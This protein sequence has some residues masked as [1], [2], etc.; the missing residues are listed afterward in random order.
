MGHTP[1]GYRIEMG[2]AVI[3]EEDAVKIRRLYDNYLSGMSLTDAA[4]QAGINTYHG[5]VKRIMC[6]R[7]Y[8][9]DEYYPA[10]I[11]SD[12]FNQAQTELKRRAVK[13]GRVN[14][15]VPKKEKQIPTQF[16]I[17]S[18]EKCFEDPVL[19]AEYVYS[20]IKSEVI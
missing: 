19:Q 7:H 6:N 15:A 1:L 14:K 12:I 11:S 4:S 17:A 5:T 8:L 16:T 10:I 20:L 18:I 3:N 13:L 2:K 9:G